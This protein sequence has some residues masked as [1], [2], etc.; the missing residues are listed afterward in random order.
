MAL[1]VFYGPDS[2]FTV[3]SE[4]FNKDVTA[5]QAEAYDGVDNRADLMRAPNLGGEGFVAIFKSGAPFSALTSGQ[6]YSWILYA[7]LAP[8]STID[9]VR[10]FTR[11][12]DADLATTFTL[13]GA[14]KVF[15]S[16]NLYAGIERVTNGYYKCIIHMST[17]TDLSG[18]ARIYLV[19]N[20][21]VDSQVPLDGVAG[22]YISDFTVLEGEE[23]AANS[24]TNTG[25]GLT[26]GMMGK[27]GA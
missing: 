8:G 23:F 13:T 6:I 4:L 5:D 26:F 9:K 3:W 16:T 24:L 7:K 11:S 20:N 22:L 19:A 18:A 27:M 10:I 25:P 21:G 12:Y 2:D 14:G 1:P 17:I 15:N